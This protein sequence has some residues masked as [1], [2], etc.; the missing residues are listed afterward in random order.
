MHPLK[1][2]CCPSHP[3]APQPPRSSPPLWGDVTV[4]P[5]PGTP[6]PTLLPDRPLAPHSPR[7][8][9][10]IN[11]TCFTFPAT[12]KNALVLILLEKWEGLGDGVSYQNPLGRSHIHCGFHMPSAGFQSFSLPSAFK[13]QPVITLTEMGWRI[14]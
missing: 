13:A 2:T 5:Q 3:N 11:A 6:A 10:L 4:V 1:E 7:D 14:S 8:G 12:G 9:L